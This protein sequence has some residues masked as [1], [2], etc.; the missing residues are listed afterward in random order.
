MQVSFVLNVVIVMSRQLEREGG[1]R[2]SNEGIGLDKGQKITGTDCSCLGRLTENR[3]TGSPEH[4][5]QESSMLISQ[6]LNSILLTEL[7]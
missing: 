7:S 4:V 2:K 1:I 3:I 6:T 5:N